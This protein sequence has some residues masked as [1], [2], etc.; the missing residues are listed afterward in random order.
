[1]EELSTIQQVRGWHKAAADVGFVPTMGALHDGHASLIRRSVADGPVTIVSIFVNPTQFGPNE[2]LDEYPRTLADDLE[3]CR[4]LGADAVFTPDEPMMYPPGYATWVE[5][6]GLTGKLCGAS[7][8]EHFKGVTTVVSKLFNIVQ[9]RR[10]YFGQKD[11]QQAIVLKRM[12]AD[13]N[14]PIEIITCPI[15]R[16]PDGLAL[17]SRNKYLNE[18]ERRRAL[19]L[20]RAL[21]EVEDKFKQG[22]RNTNVL[23]SHLQVTIG[24]E[25][26]KLDYAEI[27]TADDLSELAEIDR[28]AI[29]AVAAYFGS[30]RLID[31]VVLEV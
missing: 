26:D 9:P 18:D 23:R 20:R 25:A 1:M 5:V 3:L 31:N 2:D 16:E 22:T 7:R 19:V 30:T 6:D 12:A 27:L 14:M 24:E 21:K 17:S 4:N 13:L 8:P 11:A 15:V 28:A 29:A 10:A